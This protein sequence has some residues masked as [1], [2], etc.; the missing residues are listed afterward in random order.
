MGG[1]PTRPNVAAGIA[2]AVKREMEIGLS[3]MGTVRSK[4]WLQ[5]SAGG[6]HLTFT[7]IDNK[8]PHNLP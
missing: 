5:P 7:K 4:S 6:P 2:K 1:C 8:M 3:A